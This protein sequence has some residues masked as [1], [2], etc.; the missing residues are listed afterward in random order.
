MVCHNDGCEGAVPSRGYGIVKCSLSRSWVNFWDW[1]PKATFSLTFAGITQNGF[2][3][4]ARSHV[5]LSRD[6]LPICGRSSRNSGRRW[7]SKSSRIGIF[8]LWTVF[9][10]RCVALRERRVVDPCGRW[11]LLVMMKLL[12]KPTMDCELMCVWRGPGLSWIVPWLPP[13]F[14]TL[15]R[16]KNCCKGSMDL[17]W[18]IA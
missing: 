17:P 4:C 13:I 6:K 10:Y 14:T 3:D 16:Q 12:V 7:R 18:Q 15:R 1:I 11:L 9:L 2:L 8:P 5:P